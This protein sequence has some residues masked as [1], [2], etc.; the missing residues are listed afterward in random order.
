MTT[1]I[2]RAVSGREAPKTQDERQQ[3]VTFSLNGQQYC[4]D[5]MSVREI[6]ML[7]AITALPGA[8]DSIRG[9]INLRGTIVPICD[10][11]LRF[12]QGRTKITPSHAV[13]VVSVAGRL[14][15]LLVD[16]VLDIVTVPRSEVAPIP[17]ADSGR[18][19]PF[20]QGL[21][22]QD[23]QMLIVI[24]LERLVEAGQA[25]DASVDAPMARSSAAAA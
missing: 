16:E 24:D 23:D 4:V 14:T 22:T 15:G 19:N 11:R 1:A 17:D 8:P 21:I 25:V 7:Q 18:R 6:R 2:E 5:I 12:G 3:F 20:F 13:V 9:V 10:P